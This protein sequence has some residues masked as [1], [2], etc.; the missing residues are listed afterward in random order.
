MST[1]AY[2][3]RKERECLREAEAAID[4]FVKENWASMAVS[5]ARLAAQAERGLFGTE[6]P[7]QHGSLTDER[8]AGRGK[9][10]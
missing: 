8:T 3:R 2:Y 4:Q 9:S 5:W 10:S 6:E 1:P 7:E